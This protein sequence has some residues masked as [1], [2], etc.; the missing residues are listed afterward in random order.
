MAAALAYAVT[1]ERRYGEDAV[2]RIRDMVEK[3]QTCFFCTAV[4]TGGSDAARPMS[5]RKV[6][7][8]VLKVQNY[9]Y[10]MGQFAQT[11]QDYV[12]FYLDHMH[13]EEH[14]IMPTAVERLSD[15]DWAQLDAA[16]SHGRRP[17][18]P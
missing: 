18:Q 7:D 4:A 16:F 3:A 15:E 1:R 17:L 2:R 12:R 13:V 11:A 6:D 10:A 8:A 14:Q 9:E 5:V